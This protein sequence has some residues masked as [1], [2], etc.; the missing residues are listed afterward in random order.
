MIHIIKPNTVYEETFV[1]HIVRFNFISQN[2][3]N[4]A[5]PCQPVLFP[6]S[7]LGVQV[8]ETNLICTF[9][10]FAVIGRER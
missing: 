2:L 7:Q 10:T 5:D 4:T 6:I 1:L 3:Q 8:T 9:A